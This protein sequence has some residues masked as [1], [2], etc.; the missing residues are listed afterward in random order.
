MLFRFINKVLE[1]ERSLESSQI[2][3]DGYLM[4]RLTERSNKKRV[5]PM[6]LK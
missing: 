2:S 5:T 3:E 1:E 4:K 6:A